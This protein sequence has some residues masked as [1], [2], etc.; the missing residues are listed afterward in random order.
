MSIESSFNHSRTIKIGG[1]SIT[2]YEQLRVD[3]GISDHHTATISLS[4]S[5]LLES[6]ETVL[7]CIK[8]S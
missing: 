5:A 4:I 2:V 7:N 3:Q 8:C 1:K 6:N